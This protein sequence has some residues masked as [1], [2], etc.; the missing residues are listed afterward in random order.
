[1]LRVVWQN[2][3]QSASSGALQRKLADGHFNKKTLTRMRV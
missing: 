1:V 2:N 3:N